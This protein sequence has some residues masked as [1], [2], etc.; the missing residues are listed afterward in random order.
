MW[1]YCYSNC[2]FFN[3]LV[4]LNFII[5][6]LL[7]LYH[8]LSFYTVFQLK[9]YPVGLLYNMAIRKKI[10]WPTC[11]QAIKREAKTPVVLDVGRWFE[12]V[13]F[14]KYFLLLWTSIKSSNVVF[15][16]DSITDSG[17]VASLTT[18]MPRVNNLNKIHY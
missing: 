15:R 2:F 6:C 9:I 13:V 1:K 10:K 4:S 11:P 7:F 8:I 14:E 18:V 3:F 17:I 5:K 16:W 12:L